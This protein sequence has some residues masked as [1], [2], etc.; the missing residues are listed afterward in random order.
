MR[1]ER[2]LC[3]SDTFNYQISRCVLK[4]STR[5]ESGQV[6]APCSNW[7]LGHFIDIVFT[8]FILWRSRATVILV[9]SLLSSSVLGADQNII[10]SNAKASNE[11]LLWGPYRPNLYFGVKPR[12]PKSLSTG[13]LWGRV[14]DY[15]SFQ[16]S[17]LPK[18]F[19][20]PN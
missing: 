18:L 6:E 14:D 11:S 20:S 13:L 3:R 2:S 1:A 12:I 9:L 19:A 8:M 16:Q 5:W 7:S 4:K 15:Q 10:L 17:M